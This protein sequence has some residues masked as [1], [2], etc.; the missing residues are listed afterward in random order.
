VP[1][2]HAVLLYSW[3]I[4][5]TREPKIAPEENNPASLAKARPS[6]LL[7]IKGLPDDESQKAALAR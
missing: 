3:P 5:D 4:F 7:G 2:W 6:Q 1:N